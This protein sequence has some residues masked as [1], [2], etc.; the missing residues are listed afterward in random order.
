MEVIQLE[1]IGTF[2]CTI[3]QMKP[4]QYTELEDSQTVFNVLLPQ[5]ADN[6]TKENLAIFLTNTTSIQ[7]QSMA[8]SE[9]KKL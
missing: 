1:H 9:V 5:F 7:S 4:V 2:I 3:S 6:A 8:M